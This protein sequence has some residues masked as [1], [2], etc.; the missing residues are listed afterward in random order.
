MLN[1]IL[2]D[3]LKSSLFVLLFLALI[4]PFG[5]DR[6]QEGRIVFI[7]GESLL[8]A[9]VI[10]LS[11]SAAAYIYKIRCMSETS[12]S[13]FFKITVT[14]ITLITLSL[15]AALLCYNGWWHEGE[16]FRYWHDIDG[17]LTLR[18]WL[19]M[20]LYVAII[21]V[22]VFLFHTFDYRTRKLKNELNEVKAINMLLE[23]RQQKLSE[24]ENGEATDSVNEEKPRNLVTIEGQGLNATLRLDP[25]NIIY[26]E[27]M[28]NYADIC[29]IA[30][31]ETKH[32]T[33]RITL[34]Q[35]RASLEG[36]A[37]IVQCHRAFLVNIDFVMA[38]SS[39]NQGYQLQLFGIEK[40]I[41]VSRANT[42]SI[43]LQLS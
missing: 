13:T 18:P 28:A 6:M 31:N 9:V 35:I 2:K 38:M 26:V 43:K 5:I 11:S 3:T 40:Q 25:A 39:R 23:Q 12:A 4:Q 14:E 16:A 37:S 17:T 27:S 10:F 15:G 21:S 29:Y 36:I 22:F 24:E 30:D 34:K 33:L 8:A 19:T 32:T 7:L 1:Q 42:E 41:P 20:C